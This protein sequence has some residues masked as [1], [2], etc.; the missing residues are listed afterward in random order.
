ME[1]YGSEKNMVVNDGKR[2][3]EEGRKEE[4]RNCMALRRTWW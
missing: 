3:D 4:R 2:E 1:L